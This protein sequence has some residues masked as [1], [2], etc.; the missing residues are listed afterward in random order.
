MARA[1]EEILNHIDD[2]NDYK[3]K[4]RALIAKARTKLEKTIEKYGP[5]PEKAPEGNK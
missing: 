1:K 5:Q 2:I 4:D 3:A